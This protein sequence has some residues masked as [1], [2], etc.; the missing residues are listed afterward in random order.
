MASSLCLSNP[1]LFV[2]TE[3]LDGCGYRCVPRR[4]P[5]WPVCRWLCSEYEQELDSLVLQSLFPVPRSR[6]HRWPQDGTYGITQAVPQ[7]NACCCCCCCCW[8]KTK[9]NRIKRWKESG[10]KELG[11]V[12]SVL[13]ASQGNVDNI[14]TENL[15]AL[16]LLLLLLCSHL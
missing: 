3:K 6:A 15:E 10:A 4:S 5:R 16:L 1:V 14:L 2:P 12:A 8:L 9:K 7:G 13:D 11:R